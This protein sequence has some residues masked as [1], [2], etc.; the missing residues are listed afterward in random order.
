MASG[1]I[2]GPGPFRG[3]VPYDEGS[4]G[5]FFGRGADT[6]AIVEQIARE[7]ARVTAITG[8]SGAG[9]TSL[10]RAALTPALAR[11]G[12]QVLYLGGYAALD[13]ELWQ[14]ASRAGAEGPAAGESASDYLVRVARGS[15]A[16]TILILDHLETILDPPGEGLAQLGALLAAAAAGTGPRLRFLLVVESTV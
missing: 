11:K 12:V 4:A 8:E 9:K 3:L 13:Q 10:V 5:L 7:G 2:P 6:A 14:A 1:G 16:G 15:R